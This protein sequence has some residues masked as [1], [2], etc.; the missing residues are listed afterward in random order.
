VFN[1]TVLRAG[2]L[3]TAT[4]TFRRNLPLDNQV[5]EAEAHTSSHFS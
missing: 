2:S 4:W 3:V 5:L 1:N